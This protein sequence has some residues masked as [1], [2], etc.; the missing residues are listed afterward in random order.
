MTEQKTSLTLADID[1]L[2]V[3]EDYHVFPGTTITV[4]CL[5]L[6]N[7]YTVT[8]EAACVSAHMFDAE[9]GR[10]HARNKA[11]EKI[12]E[13]EGYLL[14]EILSTQLAESQGDQ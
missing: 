3:A 6:Q 5:T 14:R 13:L 4:C 10:M 12:W 1:A 8:G 9:L 11:R 7:G 2:I